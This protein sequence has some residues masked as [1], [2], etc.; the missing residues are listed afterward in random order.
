VSDFFDHTI[1]W[2]IVGTGYFRRPAG[3]STLIHLWQNT[4][5]AGGRSGLMSETAGRS[6]PAADTLSLAMA[7][8]GD[9]T[10]T[11]HDVIWQQNA[12]TGQRAVVCNM[13]RSTWL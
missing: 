9:S 1:E 2:Q 5:N 7:V 10:A 6:A 12:S 13:D 3:F 8:T 4:A 11:S